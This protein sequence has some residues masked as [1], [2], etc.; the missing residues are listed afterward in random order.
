MCKYTGAEQTEQVCIPAESRLFLRRSHVGAHL[1]ILALHNHTI[2]CASHSLP[3]AH[4]IC[5]YIKLAALIPL[6]RKWLA[7]KIGRHTCLCGIHAKSKAKMKL[8][9]VASQSMLLYALGRRLLYRWLDRIPEVMVLHPPTTV[10][11]SGAAMITRGDYTIPMS[12]SFSATLR[13]PRSGP[14]SGTSTWS[15]RNMWLAQ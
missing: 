8:L 9:Q 3:C 2:T 12:E 13:R 4:N 5:N 15:P 7:S 14:L 1:G 11:T 6:L 10:K